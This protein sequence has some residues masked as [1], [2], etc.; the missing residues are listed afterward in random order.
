MMNNRAEVI[1][2]LTLEQAC[3]IQ[4]RLNSE[5]AVA[6]SKLRSKITSNDEQFRKDCPEAA[7]TVHEVQAKNIWY[8]NHPTAKSEECALR[9]AKKSI[10]EYAANLY[11]YI[12]ELT[13]T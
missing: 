6:D 4:E 1:A 13:I 3:S 2:S 12:E 7:G 8:F 11:D 9:K 5:M 10:E